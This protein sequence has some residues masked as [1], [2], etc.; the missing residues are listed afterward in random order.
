MPNARMYPAVLSE[1]LS[2]YWAI[3]AEKLNQIEVALMAILESRL[4]DGWQASDDNYQSAP[5]EPNSTQRGDV[6]VIPITGTITPRPS[7]FSSGGTSAETVG[8]RIDAAKNDSSV[9]NIMLN[10]D[11][12]GGSVFGI[13]E[14]A[15]KIR[16]AAQVKPVHAIA[17]HTAAS[18]GYWL[19]SQAT[20]LAV[21][22]G[23]QVGS[24]GVISRRTDRTE[25]LLKSG[26]VVKY[27]TSGKFKAEGNPDTPI[28]DA[29]IQDMQNKSN[30][31]Y[32]KFVSD[33][34]IGRKTSP[35]LVKEAYGN[36]RMFLADEALKLGMVDRIATAEQ[37]L[38][39]L[40]SASARARQARAVAVSSSM[41]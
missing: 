8:K 12:P 41:A 28:S 9:K 6:A 14:L 27:I 26:V 30:T 1:F 19:G 16:S 15:G 11:S 24:I 4:K 10:I 33:V 40:R 29:E 37:V 7:A 36:G 20:T 31:Y 22:P 18:A 21:A 38:G 23:G 35:M 25:S 39:E 17:N 5:K 32:N 2:Q 34:A 13:E 3:E